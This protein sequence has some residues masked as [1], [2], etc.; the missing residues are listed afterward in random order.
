M[1]RNPCRQCASAIPSTMILNQGLCNAIIPIGSKGNYN[2][3]KLALTTGQIVG[4]LTENPISIIVDLD[5]F[6]CALFQSI[7]VVPGGT[8]VNPEKME[9][10]VE[11]FKKEPKVESIKK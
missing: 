9:P 5:N 8:Q 11:S 2:E 7:P 6:T 3:G 10:K 4:I 1:A